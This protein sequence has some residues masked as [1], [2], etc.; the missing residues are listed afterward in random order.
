MSLGA[1]EDSE[2]GFVGYMR[3]LLINGKLIGNYA[4]AAQS[5]HG[6]L[7]EFHRKCEKDDVMNILPLANI[8]TYQPG[9]SKKEG[10]TLIVIAHNY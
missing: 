9:G 5:R 6:L 1:S 10:S 2:N 8:M 4:I 3:S 7:A